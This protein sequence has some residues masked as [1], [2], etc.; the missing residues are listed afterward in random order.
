MTEAAVKAVRNNAAELTSRKQAQD[1]QPEINELAN[2][3]ENSLVIDL[4]G[5]V[6]MTPAYFDELVKLCRIA[7]TKAHRHRLTFVLKNVPGNCREFHRTMASGKL[8]QINADSQGNWKL[9]PRT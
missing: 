7:E 3:V 6:S 5:T 4:E 2:W 1:L 8:L 9:T